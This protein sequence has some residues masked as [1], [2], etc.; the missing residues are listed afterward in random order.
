MLIDLKAHYLDLIVNALEAAG[1]AV[2][3]RPD[4]TGGDSKGVIYVCP[5]PRREP[6]GLSER[7]VTTTKSEIV[8]AYDFGPEKFILAAQ[9]RDSRVPFKWSGSYQDGLDDLWPALAKALASN[10]LTDKRRAA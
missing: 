6:A 10:R 3:H 2:L 4:P 1:M 9:F 8:V 5:A 7:T